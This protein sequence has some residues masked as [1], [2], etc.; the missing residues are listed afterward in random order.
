VPQVVEV[1]T[2]DEYYWK[3]LE[4]ASMATEQGWLFRAA[5]IWEVV[6]PTTA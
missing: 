4:E 1:I 2:P 3:T 5:W 6:L